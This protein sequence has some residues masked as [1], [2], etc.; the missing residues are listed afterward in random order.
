M[1]VSS[2][3][4]SRKLYELSGWK[5]TF[6]WWDYADTDRSYL[7]YPDLE[8][9][10]G[11]WGTQD[12][13]E[14]IPAYDAGYLLKKLPWSITVENTLDGDN[15]EVFYASGEDKGFGSKGI[16][17]TGETLEEALVLMALRLLAEKA[18]DGLEEE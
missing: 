17:V 16:T 18:I 11:L 7:S 12:I 14:R 9:K 2:L 5:N 15:W 3:G 6:S 13:R 10:Y 8:K 1:D 4:L